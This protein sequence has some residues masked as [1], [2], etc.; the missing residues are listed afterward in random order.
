ME[1][2]NWPAAISN[3]ESLLKQLPDDVSEMSSLERMT[4]MDVLN[5]LT[6]AQMNATR[7]EDAYE[8]AYERAAIT[9]KLIEQDA[10]NVAY[11]ESH[12]VSTSLLGRAADT[13]PARRG[14]ALHWYETGIADVIDLLLSTR[15]RLPGIALRLLKDMNRVATS[16]SQ[17]EDLE[18]VENIL[19]ASQDVMDA[20]ID[21]V[22]AIEDPQAKS[23]AEKEFYLYQASL[24]LF[25]V[26]YQNTIEKG[27]DFL[28]AGI[29]GLEQVVGT[30]V[31][32]DWKDLLRS[33]E[34]AMK[35][36]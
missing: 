9:D 7:F 30:P 14:D 22:A 31:P 11:V 4:R 17:P 19:F 33:S 26:D 12:Y 32:D 5:R 8:S 35:A 2:K 34:E 36:P 29:E 16:R 13:I 15:H 21:S 1:R 24:G 23:E 18:S 10:Y 28:R 6:E 25:L 27:V 3:Y 20:L